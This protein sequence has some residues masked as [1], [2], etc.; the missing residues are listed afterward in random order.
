MGT[1]TV[2]LV[3]E[4]A[5]TEALDAPKNTT[6][7]AAVALKFVPVIVTVVPTTPLVERSL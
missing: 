3:A 1:L 7:C 6:F 4:A 5:V 2:K